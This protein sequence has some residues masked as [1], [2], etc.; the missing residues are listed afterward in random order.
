[1]PLQ[2]VKPQIAAGQSLSAVVDG[3][4]GEMLAITI[5]I[6]WTP[7]NLSFQVSADGN[8]Y[9]DVVDDF[10]KEITR[11]AVAG[12]ALTLGMESQWKGMHIK[13]RSG[14]RDWPVKQIDDVEFTVAIA[15]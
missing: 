8:N 7:A 10:G 12:T 6:N 5:P 13:L 14:S 11:T 15:T 4:T 2:I 9:Y 3:T 1:M